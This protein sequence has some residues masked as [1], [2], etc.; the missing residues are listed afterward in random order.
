MVP[1]TVDYDAMVHK[2][3]VSPRQILVPRGEDT[4][5]TMFA[6]IRIRS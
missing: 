6:R 2:R 1:G 5:G 4:T 3:R